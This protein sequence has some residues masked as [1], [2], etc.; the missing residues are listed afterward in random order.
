MAQKAGLMANK[1]QF[2][3]EKKSDPAK[4]LNSYWDE[5]S[6]D[7]QWLQQRKKAYRANLMTTI[8]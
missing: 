3:E 4:K 8:S 7:V 5:K 2:A 1:D 6:I